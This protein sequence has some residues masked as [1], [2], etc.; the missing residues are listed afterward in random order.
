MGSY[1]VATTLLLALTACSSN[2][3]DGGTTSPTQA[4]PFTRPSTVSATPAPTSP[5]AEASTAAAPDAPSRCS[6][7]GL[8]GANQKVDAGLDSEGDGRDD[9]VYLGA[10]RVGVR[11]SR[12]GSSSFDVHS[13]KPFQVLAVDA[14]PQRAEGNELLVIAAS[15]SEYA[16]ATLYDLA[17]CTFKPVMNEQGKPYTFNV[18]YTSKT[19][20]QAGVT[21]ED[22]DADGT[23]DLVGLTSTGIHVNHKADITHTIVTEKA[24]VA[25]NGRS[26]VFT[27]EEGT[28]EFKAAST[29]ACGDRKPV[30]K[31]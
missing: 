4:A 16:S 30:G 14:D 20:A 9:R 19:D 5:S 25:V 7:A 1:V 28:P 21:C 24:G 8:D 17:D 10:S 11:F 29:A 6:Q 26:K 3:K 2:G 22:L 27:V 23:S 12:G 13:A 31:D 15:T 18:G